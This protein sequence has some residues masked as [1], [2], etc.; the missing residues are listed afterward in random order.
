VLQKTVSLFQE[1]VP[2]TLNE[3]TFG[4]QRYQNEDH[5]N[6]KSAG[7]RGLSPLNA[8]ETVKVL[9]IRHFDRWC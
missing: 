7:A 5:K 3:N 9:R 4:H 6:W 8:I 2:C 1:Q